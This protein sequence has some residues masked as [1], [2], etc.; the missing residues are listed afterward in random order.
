MAA[1]IST[2]NI[3]FSIAGALPIA[4][5]LEFLHTNKQIRDTLISE[6]FNDKYFTDRLK[7]VHII[8]DPSFQDDLLFHYNATNVFHFRRT[9]NPMSCCLNSY[10]YL[11]WYLTKLNSLELTHDDVEIDFDA[12]FKDQHTKVNRSLQDKTNILVNL[13][14][15]IAMDTA[16]VEWNRK[17]N[18]KIARLIKGYTKVLFQ[19]LQDA[20]ANEEY[21]VVS[22]IVEGLNNL[23]Q[24]E[25][26]VE[27]FKQENKFPLDFFPPTI[28]D[29]AGELVKESLDDVTDDLI[30]FINEKSK[31]IDSCFGLQLPVMLMYVEP[32]IQKN[33]IE[34][35]F[36]K[37]CGKNVRITPFVYDSLM[38]RL[39]PGLNESLN[40]GDR[41]KT[42]LRTFI[43]LYFE[44]LLVQFFNDD[45]ANFESESI[46]EIHNFEKHIREQ[47]EQEKDTIYKNLLTEYN[48]DQVKTNKFELLTNFTKI[49]NSKKDQTQQEI[50]LKLNFEVLNK[51]LKNLKTFINFE[52]SYKI[53][54]S[55]RSRIQNYSTFNSIL[56]IPGVTQI[57]TQAQLNSQIEQLFVKL[58][59]VLSMNHVKPGFEKAMDL[60]SKYDPNEFKSLESIEHINTV[61][62]LVK[63][64]ELI[65]IGDLIQQMLEIFFNNELVLAKITPKDEFLNPVNQA[66]KTFESM[67]DN[68]VAKGLNLGIDKLMDE[69]EFIFNAL[70]LINDFNPKHMGNSN[71][72]VNFGPTKCAVKTVELLSNHINLLNGSTEKGIIDVFQQ[73]IGERFFQIIVKNIKKRQ[74]STD[75]AIILI[76]DL[77]LYYDFITLTL[78]QKNITPFFIALKEVGQLYLIDTRDSKELGKLVMDLTKFNGI[79]KQEEIYEFVQRRSDWTKI[80]KDVERVMYG[81]GL[82]DCSIM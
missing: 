20:F 31:I 46:Q 27:F 73:E 60:L 53:I 42:L 14:K 3:V 57:I 11:R 39:V 23:D 45:I 9:N 79:F 7:P 41:Y 71:I 38:A 72:P 40:A 35:F 43:N 13:K 1:L 8:N 37:E 62:P 26:I 81:L 28:L 49:F 34:G 69:I 2:P 12:F 6:G 52:L 82:T 56:Q 63:F 19:D 50:T 64:T 10:K 67:L 80:K 5:Y 25:L 47:E 18:V 32:V 15:F 4:T 70:Q 61:E 51:N 17:M 22:L 44:P 68:F 24:E 36:S 78:R 29:S 48:N 58:L 59:H 55:C 77:N 76:S 21:S 16:N 30:K 33:I 75:G 66:K 54:E 74:V 65:N